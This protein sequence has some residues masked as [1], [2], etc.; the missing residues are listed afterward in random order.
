M[1]R[2]TKLPKPAV[3][4][5]NEDSW[6]AEYIA[7]KTNST[8]KYRYRNTS[9]KSTLIEETASKCVYC[10]SKV[11]HNTP[12][13]VEHKVPSSREENLHFQWNNLTIAC[14]ECNRRKNDYYD[15]NYPFVDPY[16]DDVESMFIH[17]GPIVMWQAGD[18]R[19]EIAAA[20][21]EL[22][23][24]NRLPLIQR[25]LEKIEETMDLIGRYKM[26]AN[27][28]MKRLLQKRLDEMKDK[29]SEYSAMVTAL[30]TKVLATHPLTPVV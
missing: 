20:T 22:A 6:L 4:A 9:I 18:K 28:L 29:G 17:L 14:T 12:G 3:L 5:E 16:N 23:S 19:A 27:D 11:G 21:L 25:K 2:L 13:D 15:P 8:K 10:E 26:E 7:D 30:Q 24:K 1:R